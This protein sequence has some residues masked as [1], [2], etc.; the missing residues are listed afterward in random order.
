MQDHVKSDISNW[1][2]CDFCS[3]QFRDEK[4]VP[5]H[6]EEHM[7]HCEKIEEEGG[8]GDEYSVLYGVNRRSILMELKYFNV[9]DGGLL[10]DI[11]HD[12]LEGA[13]VCEAKLIMQH[14]H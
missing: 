14:K 4:F 1:N 9:C 7:K 12:V 5:R 13:L 3:L 6:L 8:R 11:M 10:P 2:T